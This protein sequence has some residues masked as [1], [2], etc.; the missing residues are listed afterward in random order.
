MA[1][2]LKPAAGECILLCPLL[3]TSFFSSFLR[4]LWS[5]W[6]SNM[7]RWESTVRD[8]LWLGEERS[9]GDV[10]GVSFT[11]HQIPCDMLMISLK[12]HTSDHIITYRWFDQETG[13]W[14]CSW[15]SFY[16]FMHQSDHGNWNSS[17]LRNLKP[18]DAQNFWVRRAGARAKGGK[19]IL[20]N[21]HPRAYL[22]NPSNTHIQKHG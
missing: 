10:R 14:W 19:A 18:H 5:Y 9:F 22:S 4:S 20:G 17:G 7:S 3:R 16:E 2:L 21:S 15:L 13:Q 6:I 8:G 1:I 12:S 11:R